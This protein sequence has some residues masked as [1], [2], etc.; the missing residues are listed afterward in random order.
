MTVQSWLTES[1]RAFSSPGLY[2]LKKLA[3]RDKRRIIM[4]ASTPKA[5][6]EFN[7]AC[8]ISLTQ[9]SSCEVMSVHKMNTATATSASPLP[10]V[11]TG[12]VRARL[13]WG[14]SNP[15]S[16]TANVDAAIMMRSLREMQPFMY[17]SKFDIESFF[18]GS[19][20]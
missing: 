8:T 7:L 19:G 18:Y 4:D 10:L 3:G 2:F 5:T 12:P 11:S 14:K 16:V 20:V 1:D 9:L 6:F 15:T 13:S 17:V